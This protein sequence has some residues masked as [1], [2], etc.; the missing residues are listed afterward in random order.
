MQMENRADSFLGH[1]EQLHLYRFG[2]IPL[3]GHLTKIMLIRIILKKSNE[4]DST[5]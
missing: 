5:M 3:R 2:I 1:I 4:E